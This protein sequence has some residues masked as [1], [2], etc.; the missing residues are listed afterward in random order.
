LIAS[1]TATNSTAAIVVAAI[2]TVV[3][4]AMIAAVLSLRRSARELRELADEL[5]DHAAAVL[6]DAEDTIRQARG[7]LARVDDLIGSAEAITN[8][9]G[10]A[11]GI[12]HAAFATPL[13]K[14]LAISHGTARA[15]KRLRKAG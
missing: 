2:A 9:V 14:V 6:G 3:V 10:R 11:T 15:R 4:V 1:T 7:E 8:T 12:A 5:S 13:I